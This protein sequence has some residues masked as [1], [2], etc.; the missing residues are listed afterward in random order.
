M[1]QPYTLPVKSL[2]T[3]THSRV[4]LY[5]YYVLQ[6][7]IIVKTSKLWNNT[8]GIIK[9]L[10][11][12]RYILDFRFL[13][14]ATLCLDDNFAHTWNSLNQLHEEC[15]SNSLEGVPT[16]AE[17]LLAAFPSLCGPTHPKPSQLGEVRWLWKPGHLMQ[18]SIALLGQIALTEAWRCILGRCPVEKQMIVPLSTYQMGCCIAAECCGSH[19]G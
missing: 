9:V 3:H 15:F 18:H 6:C 12:S 17:H 4:F 10:N 19:A 13:K 1:T 11:K 16:Y 2:D 8:Y 7:V 5:F 14:V